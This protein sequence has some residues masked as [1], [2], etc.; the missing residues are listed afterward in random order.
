M[1]IVKKDT[2]L[3]RINRELKELDPVQMVKVSKSIKDKKRHGEVFLIEKES[4][5]VLKDNCTLEEIL[6]DHDLLLDDEI[7]EEK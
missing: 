4:K 2:A 1:K 6:K 7:I 3:R 5:K